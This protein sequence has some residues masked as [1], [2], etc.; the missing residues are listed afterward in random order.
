MHATVAQFAI[1]ALIILFVMYR[2]IRRTVGSQPYLPRRLRVRIGIFSVLGLLLLSLG[3][4]QPILWAGDAVGAASGGAL[5]VF[6][7]RHSQFERRESGLYYRTHTG[8]QLAV[9]AL[10]LIR[11]VVRFAKIGS[12]ATDPSA[13]PANPAPMQTMAGDPWTSGMF[14]VLIAFY[15]TYYL[16]IL[17][18][19]KERLN[20]EDGGPDQ[21]QAS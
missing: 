8:I 3:L 6:A 10:L 19:G 9:V 13:D 7:I 12:A 14:F 11:V 5:A 15:I 2:R 4:E 18:R 17:H 16:Y 20:H 21:T 1:P